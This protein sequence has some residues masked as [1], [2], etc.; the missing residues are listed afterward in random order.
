MKQWFVFH[1]TTV[2]G[3]GGHFIV[4]KAESETDALRIAKTDPRV[5]GPIKSEPTLVHH[6]DLWENAINWKARVYVNDNSIEIQNIQIA[7]QSSSPLIALPDGTPGAMPDIK[8]L[9]KRGP[10]TYYAAWPSYYIPQHDLLRLTVGST[11]VIVSNSKLDFYKFGE[12]VITGM[13]ILDKSPRARY[14][15]RIKEQA[16]QWVEEQ[17][18]RHIISLNVIQQSLR[19]SL[20]CTD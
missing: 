13:S 9:V 11:Q 20:K 2:H 4:V 19:N 1:A 14:I 10:E 17:L 16:L 15:E 8:R 6:V 3:Y 12:T 5:S 18:D 7:A